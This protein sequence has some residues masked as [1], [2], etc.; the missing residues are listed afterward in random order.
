MLT[1]VC[2]LII[3]ADTVWWHGLYPTEHIKQDGSKRAY[4]GDYSRKKI[5]NKHV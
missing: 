2:P 4:L 5:I 1:K 3:I